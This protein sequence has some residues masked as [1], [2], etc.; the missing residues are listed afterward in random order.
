M[1]ISSDPKS[2]EPSVDLVST[3]TKYIDFAASD[4]TQKLCG[5]HMIFLTKGSNIAQH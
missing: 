2:L 3:Q 1:Y 4:A 5:L